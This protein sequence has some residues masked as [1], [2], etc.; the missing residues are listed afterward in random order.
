MSVTGNENHDISLSDAATMTKNYRD[1]ITSGTTIAHCF[2]NG[3]IQDIL[4]QTGCVGIRIYYA[5]TNDGKKQLVITGVNSSG[6]DL[7]NG[8]LADRSM[9]CPAD[10][11]SA[12]PLNSNSGSY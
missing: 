6:N 7:Y 10:C 5:I 9:C 8:K 12:N 11:S 3:A 4:D 2:G 1:T